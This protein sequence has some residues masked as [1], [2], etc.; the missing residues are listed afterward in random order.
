MVQAINLVWRAA[1]S[2]FRRKKGAIDALRRDP[3][4]G[5]VV[6]SI[7]EMGPV[8]TKRYPGQE[9]I[10]VRVRPAKRAKQEIDYGRRA[11]GY[12]YG[13]LWEMTGA[14]WT[15]SYPRRCLAHFIDFLCFVDEQIPADR[16]RIYVILD[17]LDM[18][19]SHDLLLFQFQYPRW[20]FVYQPGRAAYFNLIE[21]WWKILRFIDP[22]DSDGSCDRSRQAHHMA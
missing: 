11:K 14:C 7:D 15:Q 12:V 9:A 21:P 18:H 1:R 20:E 5:S 17:N 16:E 2:G 8:A 13:A 4:E 19:H 6:L 10:D 22:K 3:P